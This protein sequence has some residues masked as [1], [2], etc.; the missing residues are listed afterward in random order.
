M[1]TNQLPKSELYAPT[2]AE[3]AVALR[4]LEAVQKRYYY[5][6]PLTP[7][8]WKP[9]YSV[10]VDDLQAYQSGLCA[11]IQQADEQDTKK[12]QPNYGRFRPT[13]EGTPEWEFSKLQ[14]EDAKVNFA[15]ND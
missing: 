13:Q 1:E 4:V 5:N 7:F 11:A 3:V 8:E 9:N 14:R 12:P 10:V 15:T 2:F 6:S